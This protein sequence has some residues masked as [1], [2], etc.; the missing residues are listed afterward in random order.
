M[1]AS[2]RD[3]EVEGWTRESRV[4]GWRGIRSREAEMGGSTAGR[5]EMSGIDVYN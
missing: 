1:R 5:G 2:I 4:W 3:V